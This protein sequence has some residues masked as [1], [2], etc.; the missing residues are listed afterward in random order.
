MIRNMKKIARI[1][2]SEYNSSN[3][4]ADLQTELNNEGARW[5][6]GAGCDYVVPVVFAS[7]YEKAQRILRVQ[8]NIKFTDLI[9]RIQF[10]FIVNR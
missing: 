1:Y 7:D 2:K 10:D 4:Q 8:V 6:L 9:E 5:V 3:V